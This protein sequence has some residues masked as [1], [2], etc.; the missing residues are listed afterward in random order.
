[1]RAQDAA[2]ARR[3]QSPHL[4]GRRHDR[5]PAACGSRCTNDAPH[6]PAVYR[7][8]R[9]KES[10]SRRAHVMRLAWPAWPRRRPATVMIV[11][12]CAFS[13]TAGRVTSMAAMSACALVEERPCPLSGAAA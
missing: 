2:A 9:L 7:S 6:K 5:D 8:Q 4:G 13:A 1:M 12:L 10:Q 11:L 3:R